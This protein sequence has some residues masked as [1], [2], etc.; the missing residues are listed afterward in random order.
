M[1]LKFEWL[2]LEQNLVHILKAALIAVIGYFAAKYLS[3]LIVRSLSRTHMDGSLVR[4]IAK[5]VKIIVYIIILLSALNALG[6]STTGLL[7]ALS[8]AAVG[9][10]LALKDSLSNIAGGI[11][12]FLSPRF[13]TGDIVEIDGNVG[14]VLQVDLMHTTIR[15]YENRHVIIPNGNIMGSKTINLSQEDKLRVDHVFSVSYD[16]DIEFVKS[17]VTEAL[18]NYPLVLKDEEI[19]VRVNEYAQSSVNISVKVWCKTEDYW[20][21]YFDVLE[22]VKDTFDK[23]GITVPFNRLDITVNEQNKLGS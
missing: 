17:A 16:D 5:T 15:T 1:L 11:L 18:K 8:A 20:T 2:Q 3:R 12:L 21:V 10:A 7:A 4:F 23:N 19:F 9:I 14:T 6:I 22:L 13:A